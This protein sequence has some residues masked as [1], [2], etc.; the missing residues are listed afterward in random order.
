MFSVLQR[1]ILMHQFFLCLKGPS[2]D[3]ISVKQAIRALNVDIV[4]LLRK[5]YCAMEF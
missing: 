1:P 5:A 2:D 4:R 3:L